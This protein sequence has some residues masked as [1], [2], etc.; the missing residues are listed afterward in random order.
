MIC[1]V[2]IVKWSLHSIL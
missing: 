2:P 1:K